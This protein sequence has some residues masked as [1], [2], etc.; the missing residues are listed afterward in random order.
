MFIFFILSGK[1]H[2]LLQEDVSRA[3]QLSNIY[4]FGVCCFFFS[5]FSLRQQGN[6]VSFQFLTNRCIFLSLCFPWH[7][8]SY[9]MFTS[10]S[11]TDQSE[12]S[13]QSVIGFQRRHHHHLHTNGS[14]SV[15]YF[16]VVVV[17]VTF[18]VV[19]TAVVGGVFGV[20]VAVVVAVVMVFENCLSC[21]VCE[22]FCWYLYLIKERKVYLLWE[23]KKIMR[24][25]P[26][27]YKTTLCH[28]AKYFS[29]RENA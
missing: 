7:S 9:W 19:V 17:G 20:I 21:C 29:S 23:K 12:C 4:S 14:W 5:A 27:P 8:V 26:S 25:H 15:F 24:K 3:F 10:G 2:C 13:L 6:S 18:T 16:I 11:R 28:P 1:N 22:G